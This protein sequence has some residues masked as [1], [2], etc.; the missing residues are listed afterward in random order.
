MDFTRINAPLPEELIPELTA[1]WEEIFENSYEDFKPIF[2]GDETEDNEDILYLMREGEDLAGT[3]HLTVGKAQ[4][5][6]GGLGEVATPLAFRRQGIAAQLCEA[7]LDDFRG[8]DG[9][10]FFLGHR[11]PSG[12]TDI[13]SARLAPTRRCQ[14]D[15]TDS[16]WQVTGSVSGGLLQ[17]SGRTNHHYAGNGST[18][19]PYD[20]IDCLST[21]LAGVG[22]QRWHIVDALRLTIVLYGIVSEIRCTHPRTERGL[23]WGGIGQRPSNWVGNGTS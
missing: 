22:R 19:D 4:P 18:T 11:Q 7:A 12:G 1:F 8:Q 16:F 23:V 2:A 15:G 14:C 13:L 17:G 21:R 3:S 9:E 20:S 5:R 10:A 6:L